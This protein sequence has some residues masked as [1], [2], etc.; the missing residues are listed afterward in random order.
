MLKLP[1]SAL[2]SQN[3]LYTVGQLYRNVD[4]QSHIPQDEMPLRMSPTLPAP[5]ENL[6]ALNNL[7]H[8]RFAL[9]VWD[10]VREVRGPFELDLDTLKLCSNLLGAL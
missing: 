5:F 4:I 2:S 8:S 6:A 3:E 10:L 9:Q 7:K 1:R